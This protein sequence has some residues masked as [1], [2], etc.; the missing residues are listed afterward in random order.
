MTPESCKSCVY[1]Y[2]DVREGHLCTKVDAVIFLSNGVRMNWP[3]QDAAK[4]FETCQ[5]KLKRARTFGR[6][7][8]WTGQ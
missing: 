2:N 6:F 7:A 8:Y 1:R 4:A 3:G 5:G